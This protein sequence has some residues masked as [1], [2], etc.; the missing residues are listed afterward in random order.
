MNTDSDD[1]ERSC[2]GARGSEAIRGGSLGLR[3]R[4]PPA[5]TPCMNGGTRK[6]ARSAAHRDGTR[7]R[8]SP[9]GPWDG[10]MGDAPGLNVPASSRGA[11]V[12]ANGLVSLGGSLGLR[13]CRADLSG[14]ENG[15]VQMRRESWPRPRTL[16]ASLSERD[17]VP[18][19]SDSG[20]TLSTD[21]AGEAERGGVRGPPVDGGER[22]SW[23][24]PEWAYT[25][26]GG[27]GEL[28]KSGCESVERAVKGV[29]ERKGGKCPFDDMVEHAEGG[30]DGVTSSSSC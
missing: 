10:E 16:D 6:R 30:R 8:L 26:D 11:S 25:S 7:G 9:F 5:P 29:K 18:G 22:V 13:A 1:A 21:G 14:K 4:P 15:V 24:S 17:S 27:A 28:L 2:P 12:S 20:C 19:M 3:G 23:L